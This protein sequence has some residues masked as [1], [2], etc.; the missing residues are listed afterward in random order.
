MNNIQLFVMHTQRTENVSKTKLSELQRISLK[1]WFL[2]YILNKDFNWET[3]QNY[4]F[5]L[6]RNGAQLKL[7]PIGGSTSR[8]FEKSEEHCLIIAQG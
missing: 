6:V 2:N 8:I 7:H 4:S 1:Y 5:N 3:L